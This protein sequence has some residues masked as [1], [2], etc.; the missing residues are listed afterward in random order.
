LSA[1][2]LQALL[3][4]TVEMD[5]ESLHLSKRKSDAIP[6]YKDREDARSK[7]TRETSKFLLR[8][9]EAMGMVVPFERVKSSIRQ[10]GQSAS[11]T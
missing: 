2:P 11:D 9:E 6:I 10:L 7:M 8:R 3:L 5:A 1:S 4:K